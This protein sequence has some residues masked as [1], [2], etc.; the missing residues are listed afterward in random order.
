M[1]NTVTE[2]CMIFSGSLTKR[3]PKLERKVV[4]G[5]TDDVIFDVDFEALVK[6][7][8][9]KKAQEFKWRDV[10]VLIWAVASSIAGPECKEMGRRKNNSEMLAE[11]VSWRVIY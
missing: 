5:H 4:E 6:S 11:A 2:V 1:R 3:S 9:Q 8:R 7:T 10:A